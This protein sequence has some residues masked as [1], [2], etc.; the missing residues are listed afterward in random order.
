MSNDNNALDW[1]NPDLQWTDYEKYQNQS[2]GG[3]YICRHKIC[4]T[5]HSEIILE[6]IE[7]KDNKFLTAKVTL[8]VYSNKVNVFYIEEEMPL[9][10]IKKR[11]IIECL[12]WLK[13]QCEHIGQLIEFLSK[14]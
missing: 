6:V 8:S 10:E 9:E 13:I 4:P 3:K 12:E 14:Q 2:R 11:A 5:Q 7:T 1:V